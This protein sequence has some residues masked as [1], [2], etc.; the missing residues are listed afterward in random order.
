M[1]SFLS[2]LALALAPSIYLA[3][4]IFAQDKYDKEP[5]KILLIAFLLGSFMVIP[6]AITELGFTKLI[7]EQFE[8][9][10][11]KDALYFFLCVALV[12]EFCK[13]LVLRFHAYRLKEFNEPFDGIVYSAFVALGFAAFENIFYVFEN[14]LSVGFLRMFTAVPAHY[15]FGVIMGYYVGKAKF[16]K[17]G[18]YINLIKGILYATIL[19]GAYDFFATQQKYPILVMFTLV[20]LFISWR[21]SKKVIKIMKEESK[22]LF[23][24]KQE[25]Q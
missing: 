7:F 22:F 10:M 17:K 21:I 8:D 12:E 20:V 23:H 6:A 3:I 25:N 24:F 18:R 14:G 19:H 11:L 1:A 13:F 15:F 5:K 9:S 16:A 2:L 4:V